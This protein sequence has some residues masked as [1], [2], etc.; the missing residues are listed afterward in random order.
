MSRAELWQALGEA[1]EVVQA[2]VDAYEREPTPTA[3]AA[4]RA[5]EREYAQR[6]YPVI[7]QAVAFQFEAGLATYH[8]AIGTEDE[9]AAMDVFEEALAALDVALQR[10][11]ALDTEPVEKGAV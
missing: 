5:A 6:L 7:G 10:A 1:A 9:A 2:A 8:A 4:M 3:Q 11:S